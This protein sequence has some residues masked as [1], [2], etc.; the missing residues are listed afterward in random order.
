[1]IGVSKVSNPKMLKSWHF[2]GI[3]VILLMLCCN[4]LYLC[5]LFGTISCHVTQVS[6]SGN[7]FDRRGYRRFQSNVKTCSTLRLYIEY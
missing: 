7:V 5:Y 4:W 1:M 2:L 6:I 3:L